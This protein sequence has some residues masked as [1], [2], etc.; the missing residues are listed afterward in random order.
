MLI[1]EEA[2]TAGADSFGMVIVKGYANPT[3]E[4][5]SGDET[6]LTLNISN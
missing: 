5:Q 2:A 6:N 1:T 4:I 3:I